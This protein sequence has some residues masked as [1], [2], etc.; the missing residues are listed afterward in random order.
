MKHIYFIWPILSYLLYTVVYIMYFC[1]AEINKI[2][3][4]FFQKR[5]NKIGTVF[6][7]FYVEIELK[8][9]IQL[10]H[11]KASAKFVA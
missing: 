1:I 2:N 3:Q 6:N 10:V 8:Y 5:F 11:L 4:F 7:F 9:H